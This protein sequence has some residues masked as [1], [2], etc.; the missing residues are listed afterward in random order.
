MVGSGD[1]GEVEAWKNPQISDSPEDFKPVPPSIAQDHP[2]KHRLTLSERYS[3]QPCDLI[4]SLAQGQRAVHSILSLRLRASHCD[5][6]SCFAQLATNCRALS[7]GEVTD[8]EVAR[9]LLRHNGDVRKT[10]ADFTIA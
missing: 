7:A 10:L 1:K 5:V 2:R 8:T 4:V 6:L 3:T 9:A